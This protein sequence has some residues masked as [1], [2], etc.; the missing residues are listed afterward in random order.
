MD[1]ATSALDNESEAIVQSALDRARLGRTTIIIAHR[2]TTI[3][4]ADVI[5]ALEKGKVAE[6]G[7]HDEL[8]AKEDVY[9]NLVINQQNASTDDEKNKGK[10]VRDE[11]IISKF[12]L[13]E[14]KMFT[15]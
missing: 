10:K 13:G 14:K 3:R 1:E 5:F 12:S 2:L 15:G 6:K 4:N 7:T 11:E 8:M 9:Y